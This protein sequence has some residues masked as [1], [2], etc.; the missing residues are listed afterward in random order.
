MPFLH[1]QPKDAPCSG[2]R[3]PHLTAGHVFCRSQTVNP[4]NAE[5]N[6]IC[7][8]LALL[9]AHLI[10][11]VSKVRV[12]LLPSQHHQG[13]SCFLE[14]S[15]LLSMQIGFAGN[16]CWKTLECV[17]AATLLP[18]TKTITCV[19]PVGMKA[20]SAVMHHYSYTIYMQ[21]CICGALNMVHSTFT[22][23]VCW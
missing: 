19:G 3:D 6:P 7:H 5:L 4:L 11:Q 14:S 2:D 15:L 16:W 9:R 17:V 23:S 8:L 13:Q 20:G 12:N 18:A 21:I 22:V 10:L 1:P